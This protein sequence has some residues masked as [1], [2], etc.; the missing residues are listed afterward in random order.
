MVR[1]LEALRVFDRAVGSR[2]QDDEQVTRRSELLDDAAERWKV[3]QAKGSRLVRQSLAG[4]D[5][6]RTRAL[7]LGPEALFFI[8]RSAFFI[9]CRA[10]LVRAIAP[11]SGIVADYVISNFRA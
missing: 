9:H 1:S 4:A 11:A 7:D 10:E 8:L 5:G 2:A 6:A 3:I